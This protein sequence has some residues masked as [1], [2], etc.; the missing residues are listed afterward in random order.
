MTKTSQFSIKSFLFESVLN[1][2]HI[3]PF[4]YTTKNICP[5]EASG[6]K[7]VWAG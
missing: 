4:E 7:P 2:P 5:V 6:L 1:V 3:A